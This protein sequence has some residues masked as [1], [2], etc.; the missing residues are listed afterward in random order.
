MRNLRKLLTFQAGLA[1]QNAFLDNTTQ[2]GSLL[3]WDEATYLIGLQY[4]EM[5]FY[6]L[7]LAFDF[8]DFLWAISGNFIKYKIEGIRDGKL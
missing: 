3:S 8:L 5:I 7:M 2:S 4:T 1:L 6:F